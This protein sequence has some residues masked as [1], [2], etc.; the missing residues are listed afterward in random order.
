MVILFENGTFL[1]YSVSKSIGEIKAW[2]KQE[3]G[4]KKR[5]FFYEQI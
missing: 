5:G 3:S 2:G 1:T 4:L